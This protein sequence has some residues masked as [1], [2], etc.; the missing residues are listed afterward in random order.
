VNRQNYTFDLLTF[1]L[2]MALVIFGWMTIYA[3]TDPAGDL[4]FSSLSNPHT[5]QLIWIGVSLFLIGVIQAVRPRFLEAIAYP[6]YAGAIL[7]LILV[8]LVGKEING[9]RSWFVIGGTQIQPTE[10]AKVATALALARFISSNNFSFKNTRDTL[11]AFGIIAL[12]AIVIVLQRDAGSALVFGSFLILFFREGLNPL[13]P[14]ALL[15]IAAVLAVTLGLSVWWAL[16]FI[17]LLSSISF[18]LTFSRRRWKSTL[19]LHVL[20]VSLLLGLSFS[21]SYVVPKLPKHQQ[22]RIMV[23]FHPYE[24]DPRGRNEAYNFK[25]SVT[26]IGSGGFWGKGYRQG[27]YTKLQFVPEQ[28]TDFISVLLVKSVAGSA[29]L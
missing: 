20:A 13:I 21:T 17:L 27:T 15:I 1:L 3:V 10:F 14:G 29:L 9:A 25:Q 24:V 19:T 2:Y 6:A 22:N 7:L 12:P 28:E 23:L 5:K 16:G 8:L 26:A 4:G 18:F 11:I